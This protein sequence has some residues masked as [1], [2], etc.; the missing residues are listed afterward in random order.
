MLIVSQKPPGEACGTCGTPHT[1]II[2]AAA[3]RATDLARAVKKFQTK[4]SMVAKLFAKHIKLPESIELCNNTK[5]VDILV[6][7]I[8]G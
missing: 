8:N 1:I 2:T 5:Y 4:E 6:S 7:K 3:L